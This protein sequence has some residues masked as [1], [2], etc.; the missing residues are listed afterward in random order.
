MKDFETD[1]LEG[2]HL[3]SIDDDDEDSGTWRQADSQE[4][5]LRMRPRRKT[6]MSWVWQTGM[7]L[8]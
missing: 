6:M 1:F 2:R 7:A 8:A 5:A 3:Q 4:D